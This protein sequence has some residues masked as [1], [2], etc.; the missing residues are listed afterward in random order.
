[1]QRELELA[2]KEASDQ[3]ERETGQAP[4]EHCYTSPHVVSLFQIKI[5]G[6]EGARNGG[7]EGVRP[8]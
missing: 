4:G 7:Q 5:E 1:V 6:A 3:I 2:A 8:V